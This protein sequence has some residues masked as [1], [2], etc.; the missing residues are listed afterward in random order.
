MWFATFAA[1]MASDVLGETAHGEL[2]VGFFG[3]SRALGEAPYELVE[4]GDERPVAGLDDPFAAYPLTDALVIG[5][6]VEARFVAPPLRLGVGWQRVY[7]DW[8]PVD[9]HREPDGAGAPAISSV[10]RFTT[11]EARFAIG[12][13]VPTGLVVPIVDL[14]GDVH[15][16]TVAL[17]ID[18]VP[19]TYRSESFSLGGRAGLRAQVSDATFLQVSGEVSP[20]GPFSWG[21]SVGVGVALY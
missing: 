15:L 10:R 13:E 7:P 16:S 8:E 3:G 17:E 14:V 6:R 11:D 9:D 21:A 1:A 12:L 20:L 2:E 5:P 4:A 18:G 19:A